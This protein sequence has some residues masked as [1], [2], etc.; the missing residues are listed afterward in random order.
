MKFRLVAGLVVALAFLHADDSPEPEAR[1]LSLNVV[2]LDSHGQPVTDLTAA[3]FQI[4]DLGKPQKIVFFRRKDASSP[5]QVPALGP[6]EFSN[7]TQVKPLHATII[8]FDLLNQGFSSRGM[9]ASQIVRSLEPLDA[10]NSLYLYLLSVDGKLY[11]VRGFLPGEGTAHP[12]PGAPWTRQI[13]PL[14]DQAL[15]EVTRIRSPDIDVYGRIQ[16]TFFALEALGAQMTAIPGQKNVVWV[17]DGV[18]MALG[19][20]RSDTLVPIDFTPQIR[21]LSDALDRS[22]VALYPVR[23]IMLGREDNIGGTSGGNGAT[24][25]A[26]TGVEEMATLNQFADLTGGRRSTDRDIGSAL[27]QAMN[28]L[29]FSYQ[30]GY[31]PSTATDGKFHKLRV[32]SER[33][34]L[35]IQA[36]AG[37]YAWA[38]PAGSRAGQAFSTIATT[39]ADAEEIGLRATVSP[40]GDGARV[41]VRIDAHDVILAQQGDHYTGQLRV[42]IVG[43]LPDGGTES[44][45]MTPVDLNYDAA[46]RGQ[47]LKDGI[48]FTE[49]LAASREESKFRVIVFDRDSEAVGSITI[50]ASAWSRSQP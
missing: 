23:Q 21:Q 41:D 6:K 11:P 30:L 38:L 20:R 14:L 29:R 19:E 4:T 27:K 12:A 8:L 44:S 26:G 22:G 36:K 35:R 34:G 16:L 3:D 5:E 28:D 46:G 15:R 49:N 24:L 10:G 37:Y 48:A 13:R 25:G 40:K 2:A 32:T 31:Y 47:A 9:A 43:Y 45:L 33:K 1:L 42:V 17:T 7:R 50:P 18:P 39:P